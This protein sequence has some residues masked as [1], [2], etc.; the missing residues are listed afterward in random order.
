MNNL[1]NIIFL[2]VFTPSL[3]FA[4][5]SSEYSVVFGSFSWLEAKLD[6]NARGGHLVTITSEEEN[7]I[8]DELVTPHLINGERD[9]FDWCHR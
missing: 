2:A 5:N 1:K 6:A 3:I 7:R 9:F 4:Q 8:V